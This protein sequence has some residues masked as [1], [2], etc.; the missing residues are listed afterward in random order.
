VVPQAGW[1]GRQNQRPGQ[2]NLI[3][4]TTLPCEVFKYRGTTY[5]LM[6]TGKETIGL[7]CP[8][9]TP[10]HNLEDSN[11][12]PRKA[13]HWRT[14][15]AKYFMHV[16]KLAVELSLLRTNEFMSGTSIGT[17]ANFQ[18]Y[19]VY[20]N[21]CVNK[22]NNYFPKINLIKFALI[23][24]EYTVNRRNILLYTHCKWVNS[25]H[26]PLVPRV[27]VYWV[28]SPDYICLITVWLDRPR[29][30]HK[31]LDLKKI[32]STLSFIYY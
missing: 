20:C 28:L 12:C 14:I 6:L 30:G 16:T 18:V 31:T 5:M 4:T 22:I 8:G 27:K 2:T 29:W 7:H 17:V 25:V 1:S 10:L 23:L 24:V 15:K 13:E 19:P 3:T 26:T 9:L 32:F 11:K 21:T